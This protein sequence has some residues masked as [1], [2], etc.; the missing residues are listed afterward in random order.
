VLERV[1]AQATPAP[2]SSTAEKNNLRD[3]AAWAWKGGAAALLLGAA[4]AGYQWWP[5]QRDMP[6]APSIAPP[7]AVT[8]VKPAI[9]AAPK[10]DTP[11]LPAAPR[12][13]V[14]EKP[15]APKLAA[16][17]PA[18]E[19]LAMA[20]PAVPPEPPTPP[21]AAQPA[22]KPLDTTAPQPQS[23]IA[24]A[25]VAPPPAPSAPRRIAVIAL[26]E[27]TFRDFWA[28]E[29]RATYS[30]KIAS[31][32]RD[33]L[34]EGASGRVELSINL[35]PARDLRGLDKALRETPS[36]C[37]TTRAGAVFV[38]RVEESFAMSRV[39]S[40]YWPEL[41]LTAIACDS[42]KQYIVRDT[43]SPRPDDGFPFERNMAETMDKF[44]REYRHLLQ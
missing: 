43:L 16:L 18:P 33:A 5:H 14:A 19:K 37:D 29:Q 30:A 11:A 20:K 2:A 1:L 36:L 3:T 24:I 32:Y 10:A 7:P 6:I 15:A 26:G 4:M 13:Q 21:T 28:G 42:G 34:R 39:E 35:D 40:A 27:P 22:P 12:P 38:A 25:T 23:K 8:H 31:L 44:A 9:P 41:R 17:K